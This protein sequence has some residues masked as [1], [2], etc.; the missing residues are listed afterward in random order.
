[1]LK[2]KLISKNKV[3]LIYIAEED[4]A[5]SSVDFV[6]QCLVDNE[7]TVAF[8]KAINKLIKKNHTVLDLGTGSGIMALSAAKA[9]A[10]KV[11]AVEFDTFVARIA[12]KATLLNKFK[13]KVSIL[14]NDAR[15]LHFPKKVKFD[16]V[17]SEMLTTGMVDESQVQV[18][19][20]LHNK[21]LVDSSTIFLPF[22]QD[23]YISLVNANFNMSGFKIPMILHLWKW[24]KWSNLKIKSVTN[25]LLLSSV[26]FNKT[27]NEKFD[28]V[29]SF[30]IKNTGIINSLYLTSRTFLTDKT[31][32]GDTEALN[33]PMLIPIS[34]KFVK[35]GEKVN[36]KINYVFGSG[37]KSFN[38]KFIP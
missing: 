27:N 13:E 35:A 22:K 8:Q 1:M 29:L 10:K 4:R 7:R 11:Y 34:E 21:K 30:K 5:F 18:M 19:N 38:A 12:S 17:I 20:N 37:Y 16:V 36:L 31:F 15:I 25:Q 9:G 23:T 33:A 26:F 28:I 14:I 3:K 24:H 6:G 32:I 2:N